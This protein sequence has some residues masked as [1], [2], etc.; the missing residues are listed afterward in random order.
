LFV[1]SGARDFSLCAKFHS[2]NSDT[3]LILFDFHV[4]PT[5]RG[6]ALGL[7]RRRHGAPEIHGMTMWNSYFRWTPK[8]SAR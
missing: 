4:R 1:W 6:E 2:W 3:L 8:K 7:L 5:A